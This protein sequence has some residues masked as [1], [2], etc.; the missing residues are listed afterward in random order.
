MHACKYMVL[1]Y[2]NLCMC[3]NMCFDIVVVGAD[4]GA[5]HWK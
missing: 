3:G 5:K 4:L 2:V 1:I